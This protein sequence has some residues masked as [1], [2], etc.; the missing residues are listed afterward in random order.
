MRVSKKAKTVY[1]RDHIGFI[2][3]A[4]NIFYVVRIIIGYDGLFDITIEGRRRPRDLC[5]L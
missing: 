2:V 3:E 5:G 4:S 1:S